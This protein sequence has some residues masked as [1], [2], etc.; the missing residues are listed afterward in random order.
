MSEPRFELRFLAAFHQMHGHGL[1]SNGTRWKVL[2][3][4]LRMLADS[5]ILQGPCPAFAEGWQC[6][7]TWPSASSHAQ[8]CQCWA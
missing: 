7:G 5:L 6:P 3:E 1:G 2:Q 8:G 4:Q